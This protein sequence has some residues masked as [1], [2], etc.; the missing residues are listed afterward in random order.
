MRYYVDSEVGVGVKGERKGERINHLCKLQVPKKVLHSSASIQFTTGN[1]TYW[2][3]IHAPPVQPGRIPPTPQTTLKMYVLRSQ[4]ELQVLKDEL[5]SCFPESLKVYGAVLNISR[6]NV[7]NQEVLVDSWPNFQVVIARPRREKMPPETNCFAQSCAVFYKGLSAYEKLVQETDAID[8]KQ[9]FLLHGL[10]R[11]VYQTSRNLAAAKGFSVKLVTQTQVFVLQ[12]PLHV[13][14]TVAMS[15]SEVKHSSIDSCHAALLN[16]TWSVGGNEQSLQYLTQLIHHFPSSC[17]MD[18]EGCPISWVLL[19]QFGCLTHAYTMPAHRG[20]GYIQ[21]VMAELAKTLQAMD[22]PVYGDVLER[23]SAMQRALQ[24]LG[25]NLPP[26][27]LFFDLHTPHTSAA[28]G[29]S[30]A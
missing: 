24:C 11:G 27:F 25:A 3:K 13:S 22:Y 18:A 15:D 4:E 19:D 29:S 23:N 7:F 9:E 20:K 6:G 17:L 30:K 5:R 26:C 2:E 1:S 10:Q 8:W 21:V 16:E 14:G 28:T 12:D